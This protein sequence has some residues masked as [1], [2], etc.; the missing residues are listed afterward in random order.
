[1][2]KYTRFPVNGFLKLPREITNICIWMSSPFDRV[3]A[4]LDLLM[5]ASF[6]ERT[7]KLGQYEL[8][9]QPGE[10]AYS[11]VTLAR[12]WKRSR[13]FVRDVLREFAAIGLIEVR[14][15]E[16]TT[17]IRIANWEKYQCAPKKP[18]QGICPETGQVLGQPPEDTNSFENGLYTQN[19]LLPVDPPGESRDRVRVQPQGE[20]RATNEEYINNKKKCSSAE[21]SSLAVFFLSKQGNTNSELESG[22]P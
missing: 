21:A 17:I 18:G 4:L 15:K 20:K 8:T 6:R 22:Y 3:R 16:F 11:T 14:T 9:I 5:L 10:L 13:H 7:V 1:M 19:I 12:R 2:K